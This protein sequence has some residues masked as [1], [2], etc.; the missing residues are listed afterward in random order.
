MKTEELEKKVAYLENRVRTLEDIE[1]IRTFHQ[2]YLYSL[3]EHKTEELIDCFADDAVTDIGSF[4]KRRGKAEI[5]KMFREDVAR[6]NT[7]NVAH[8]VIQPIITVDGNK[9]KGLWFLYMCFWDVDAPNGPI[10][11]MTQGLHDCEYIKVNGQWKF[12]SCKFSRPW[13]AQL[14]CMNRPK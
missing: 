1:A 5:R 11:E 8:W 10:V 4:G 2:R 14:E 13:P 12:S 7:W 9:G 3:N 6:L